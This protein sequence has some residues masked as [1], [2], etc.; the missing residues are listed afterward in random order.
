MIVA[1]CEA[2][3]T[4]EDELSVSVGADNTSMVDVAIVEQAP[5]EPVTV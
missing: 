3:I 5:F 2:Q 1:L 4:K